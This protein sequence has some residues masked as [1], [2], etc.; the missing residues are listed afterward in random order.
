MKYE[1]LVYKSPSSDQVIAEF[2]T[3]ELFTYWALTQS[4]LGADQVS[5]N[6][7]VYLGWDEIEEALNK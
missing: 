5:I 7:Q 4:D 6:G 2:Y 1:I 3:P